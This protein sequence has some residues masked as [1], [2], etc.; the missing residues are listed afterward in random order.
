M[1]NQQGRKKWIHIFK[2]QA[3]SIKNLKLNT[4]KTNSPN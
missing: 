2:T 4:H 3:K 1:L